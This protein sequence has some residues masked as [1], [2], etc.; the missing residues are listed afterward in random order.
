MV[1]KTDNEHSGADMAPTARTRKLV[2][3]LAWATIVMG[4]CG[5]GMEA[6]SGHWI[7]GLSGGAVIISMGV[8]ILSQVREKHDA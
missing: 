1:L 8:I 7:N 5:A 4:A 3:V 6:M 2:R